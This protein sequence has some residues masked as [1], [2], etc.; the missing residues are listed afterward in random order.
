MTGDLERTAVKAASEATAARP[1]RARLLYVDNLRIALTALV[2]LHHTAVTYGNIPVWYYT[3]PAEDGSGLLLDA[4]VMFNQAFFMGFFFMIAG[5]FTP[6]SYDRKGA[7]PFFRDRLKRL[8]IPLLAFLLLIRPLTNFSGYADL[9]ATFAERGES[10]PYWIYYVASWDAGPMWFVEVLLVFAVLYALVRRRGARRLLAS[11]GETGRAAVRAQRPLRPLAVIVFTLG[12]ALATYLWRFLVPGGSYLPFLGL[13]TPSFLPQYASF[14]VLGVFAYR[15]G[16][17]QTLSR[18]AGR[19]GWA[20][21]LVATLAYLPVVM[22][23]KEDTLSGHGTWQSLVSA[24]WES[25]FAV[26]VVLGLTVLFRERLNR[27]GRTAAFLSRHAFAVYLIH[28]PVLVGLG[29]AFRWLHAPA[30]AKFALVAVLALPLC[31][32]IA[33]AVRSLPRADRVL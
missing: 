18:V 22:T 2:V 26:G 13:P 33:Y 7:R 3:E 20:V 28:A 16:W 8:G 25:T 30:A 9:R 12:L 23:A 15:H 31:W 19:V 21:A 11:A 32:G 29:F 14:F 24:A 10:L 4:F 5:Y 17:P 27:Q 6:A 1:K